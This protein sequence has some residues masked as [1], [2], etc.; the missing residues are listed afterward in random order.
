MASKK[1]KLF[2]PNVSF[3]SLTIV[4]VTFILITGIAL[5]LIIIANSSINYQLCGSA[6]CYN[7][8]ITL[9]KL[10]LGILSLL[11]PI[12][13]IFAVQHRS[14]QSIAQIKTSEGQ[15]NFV[16]YY[17]H[18]EE[19]GKYLKTKSI[20]T[21]VH[22]NQSHAVIFEE[23]RNGD[24]NISESIQKFIETVSSEIYLKLKA[25]EVGSVNGLDNNIVISTNFQE[26]E[27]KLKV[28]N[29]KFHVIPQNRTIFSILRKKF[30]LT[31]ISERA[32]FF[33]AETQRL[34]K[35]L[36]FC[37]SYTPPVSMQAI[38]NLPSEIGFTELEGNNYLDFKLDDC[39]SDGKSLI[40]TVESTRSSTT[41]GVPT[42]TQ[43][44]I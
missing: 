41:V 35:L 31:D 13:A 16:N 14:E 9:F 19:F 30:A 37:H 5:L 21:K 38:S 12:G 22:A 36:S 27:I 11:I 6:E 17:K 26:I 7:N 18:L 3:F 8:F 32:N 44:S 23:G 24:F 20:D 4:W 29:E 2:N 33:K 40:V 43:N 28:L 1:S 15:N 39:G 42:I 10:P 34:I 25:I